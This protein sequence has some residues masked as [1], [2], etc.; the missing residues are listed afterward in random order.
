[1]TMTMAGGVGGDPEPGTIYIYIVGSKAIPI[2]IY[3]DPPTRLHN[4]GGKITP[5][6]H[7]STRLLN[8]AQLSTGFV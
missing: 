1:M 3:T 5:L 4:Y 2:V 6:S 8:T 7:K